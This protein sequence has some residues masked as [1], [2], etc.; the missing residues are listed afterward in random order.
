MVLRLLCACFL[1]L[2]SVAHAGPANTTDALDRLEEVLQLRVEDGRLHP[3]DVLPTILV[4]TQPHFEGSQGWFAIRAIEV[5]QKAFGNTGLRLCEACMAPRAF[6]EEGNLTYQTGPVGLDE[7]VRIDTQTRGESQPAKTAIWLDEHDGGVSIRIVE[8]RTGRV[9]FAQNVDPMLIEYGNTQRMY[10]LSAELERR[11]RGDSL[12]QG[13][14]D[15]AIYPGQHLS[16]DWT[17]Q[18]GKTNANLS[19]VSIS[20]LDPIVGIGACHYRRVELGNILI[21]GKALV[22]IPTALARSFG[23][24]NI[25]VFDPMLTLAGVA[26]VPFGRSNYGAVVTVSTN[27]QVGIGISL[28][29]ISL[30]P[31]LL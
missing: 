18:W 30:L 14:F 28:M 21:G 29:N 9:L 12:T 13:F 2:S 1:L 6:V 4:S 19:G 20:I 26:R 24:S 25:D 27:G 7:I 31:V 11:A 17:D 16:M 23:D 10:S 8:L 15:A 3:D 22:S 5:V